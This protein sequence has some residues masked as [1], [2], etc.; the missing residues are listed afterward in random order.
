MMMMTCLGI[1]QGFV[2][3]QLCHMTSHLR[4]PLPSLRQKK[5]G[6]Q[7]WNLQFSENNDGDDYHDDGGDES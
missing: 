2:E 3:N 4:T 1:V 6:F 5:R 7:F